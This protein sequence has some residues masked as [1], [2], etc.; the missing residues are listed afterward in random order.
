MEML[1]KL[2]SIPII[3]LQFIVFL[4]LYL[5]TKLFHSK[6]IGDKFGTFIFCLITVVDAL[7]IMAYLMWR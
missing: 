1:I 5:T 6:I 2:I 7:I 3:I 4:L